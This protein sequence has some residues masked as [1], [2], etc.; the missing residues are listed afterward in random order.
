M[1]TAEEQMT[2]AIQQLYVRLQ[3][4][5]ETLV[6]ILQATIELEEQVQNATSTTTHEPMIRAERLFKQIMSRSRGPAET[7]WN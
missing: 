3:Q 6:T 1:S 7:S 4:F 5:Q 2:M